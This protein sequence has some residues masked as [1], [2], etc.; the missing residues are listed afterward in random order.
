MAVREKASG[1]VTM[2]P[3]EMTRGDCNRRVTT[4]DDLAAREPVKGADEFDLVRER[5]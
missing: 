1:A 2:Q 3:V 4:L 5:F